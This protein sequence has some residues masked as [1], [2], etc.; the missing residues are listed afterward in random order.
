M[1]TNPSALAALRQDYKKASLD[2]SDVSDNPLQQFH[3]WFAEAQQAGVLEP[4]A[5]C[6][7]TVA[8]TGRPSS[9]I[10]LLKELDHG[11]VF[12]TNYTSRKG[13]ELADSPF[14]ALNFFW[15]VLERQVRIEG[16]VESVTAQTSD[17]YFQ[18]RPRGSQIGAWASPQSQ[19]IPNRAWLETNQSDVESRFQGQETLPRPAHWG[20]YRLIP[21]Y[22]EFW[23]GRPSRLHDRLVYKL[24]E[25]GVWTITRLAP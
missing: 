25:A 13:Q 12:Y 7:S 24:S 11:F 17:A 5:M 6:L 8:A 10:V 23:Q 18:V 22:I 2:V 16:R 9:R 21:D 19:E 20:G 14:A 15:D 1:S 4:N 3:Q